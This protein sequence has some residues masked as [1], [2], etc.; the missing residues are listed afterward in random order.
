MRSQ[1]G[2]APARPAT[3]WVEHTRRV[4]ADAGH[5]STGPRGAIVEVLGRQ[6][7]VLTAREIVDALRAEG[8]EVGIATVYRALE[9][10]ARL[11]L[12]QRL[13]VGEGFARYEPADPGGEHHH[14]LV[15]DSCGQVSPFEDE[16]LERAIGRVAG[17]LDYTVAAHDVVLR[18]R[19]PACAA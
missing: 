1:P 14:H 16:Q 15:C 18:G 11:G 4:L 8:R 6:D 7:C 5:P 2:S 13:D 19:C 17:R 3:G 9:R 12:V 10:L